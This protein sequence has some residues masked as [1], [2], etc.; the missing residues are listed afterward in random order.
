MRGLAAVSDYN[1]LISTIG[2]QYCPSCPAGLLAAVMQKESS[3][4]PTAVSSAGAQGL[5][6]IMPANDASLGITNPFDPA[7]NIQGGAT[8]LQQYYNQFGNW[9][10][11]LIA[12]NEGPGNL[13]NKGPFASSQA[14]ASSI[15]GSA[16]IST[17]PTDPAT[18][19]SV[20]SDFTSTGSVLSDTSGG[21]LGDGSGPLGLSWLTWGAAIGGVILLAIATR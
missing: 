5:M 11:A 2:A 9:N 12:Y 20:F 21:A 10:D 15:L 14:Y 18:I 1:P 19:D 6:Q 3:G 17:D 7:Q 13:Q 8:L 16:G 4:N